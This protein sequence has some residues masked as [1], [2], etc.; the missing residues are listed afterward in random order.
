MQRTLASVENLKQALA[1]M[2]GYGKRRSVS[3][4]YSGNQ[5]YIRNPRRS[6]SWELSTLRETH[7]ECNPNCAVLQMLVM[8]ARQ[9][10]G[11][12]SGAHIK[13]IIFDKCGTG[14]L[15]ITPD[16]LVTSEEEW[17]LR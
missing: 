14:T 11:P 1:S 9:Y 3:F 8:L 17:H 4:P 5:G 16:V 15:P 7:W 10:G 12:R 2:Q 13:V 6:L